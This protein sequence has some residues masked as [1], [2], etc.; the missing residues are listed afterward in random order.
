MIPNWLSV[1]G[2][3]GYTD[4]LNKPCGLVLG[5]HAASVILL[6]EVDLRDKFFLLFGASVVHMR[7]DFVGIEN[8]H[9]WAASIGL[10]LAWIINP[11]IMPI[12]MTFVHTPLHYFRLQEIKVLSRPQLCIVTSAITTAVWFAPWEFSIDSFDGLWI[13]PVISH[14]MIQEFNTTTEKL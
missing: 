1:V 3:H 11:D 14:C 13:A 9:K 12:Y 5:T 8:R 10:H 4:I 2:P 7:H 6:H